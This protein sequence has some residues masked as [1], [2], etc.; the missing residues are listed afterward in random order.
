MISQRMSFYQRHIFPRLLDLA[1]RNRVVAQYRAEIVP[2]ALG[3]VL[4]VGV[5]SGLNLPFYGPAVQRLY[6]VEPDE[7]LLEMARKTARPAG[8]PIDFLARP[9]ESL[10]LEGGCI[11]TVVT[12]FTLCTIANAQA[13]LAEMRRVLKPNGL[14]LFAEHGLAPDR[15]VQRWQ[16]RLNTTWRKWAGGCN[17]NRKIDD[18]IQEAGFHFLDL[19]KGYAKGPKV[20]SYV[21]SGSAGIVTR[22]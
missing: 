7:S 16:N 4:E 6:A 20:M 15:S 5:G 3:T 9:G 12:T 13:A 10:P 22:R 17:L 18:L 14:L 19:S 1:M 11:D 2:R 21:Y 8:F